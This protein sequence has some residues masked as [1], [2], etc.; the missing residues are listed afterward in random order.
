MASRIIAMVVVLGAGAAPAFAQAHALD[1]LPVNVSRGSADAQRFA[2]NC[3]EPTTEVER[4]T[5][6]GTVTCL[7]LPGHRLTSAGSWVRLQV[8]PALARV[9]VN[10]SY[11]GT[12]DQLAS[13]YRGLRIGLG[14]QRIELRAPGYRAQSFWI[15]QEPDRT[16]LFTRSLQ[17]N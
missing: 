2:S 8:S 6:G 3:P 10:G 15:M 5:P 12:A 4:T 16:G 11:V 9:Y 14:P 17:P 1:L 7:G 13:P